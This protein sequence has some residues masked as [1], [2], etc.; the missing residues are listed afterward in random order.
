MCEWWNR[1]V[2]NYI[3]NYV[4]INPLTLAQAR[5]KFFIEAREKFIE[6][7]HQEINKFLDS[8]HG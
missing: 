6:V 2:V 8:F 1:K 5:G 4:R 3:H 7:V